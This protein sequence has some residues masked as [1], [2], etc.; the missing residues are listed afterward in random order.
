MAAASIAAL[1]ALL[2]LTPNGAVLA[3]IPA[4]SFG[5]DPFAVPPSENIP[6]SHPTQSCFSGSLL[7][8]QLLL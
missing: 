1:V 4:L 7:N 8:N 6:A 3:H 2:Q 5:R